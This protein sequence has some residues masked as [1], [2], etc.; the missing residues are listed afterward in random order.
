MSNP[1]FTSQINGD[2]VYLSISG[3]KNTTSKVYV[4][5]TTVPSAGNSSSGDGLTN[6]IEYIPTVSGISNN[7]ANFQVPINNLKDGTQYTININGKTSANG[8]IANNFA[9]GTFDYI[10]PPVCSDIDF[11]V[12]SGDQSVIVKMDSIADNVDTVKFYITEMNSTYRPC[13]IEIDASQ[14]DIYGQTVVID[15]SYATITNPGPA[16]RAY[17]PSDSTTVGAAI[18]DDSGSTNYTPGGGFMW[19]SASTAFQINLLRNVD[20]MAYSTESPPSGSV[21]YWNGART[22]TA[23]GTNMPDGNWID[24]Q[25]YALLINTDGSMNV[26]TNGGATVVEP[27]TQWTITG[28]GQTVLRGTLDL[29]VAD[30]TTLVVKGREYRNFSS[31]IE[32]NPQESFT[33]QMYTEVESYTFDGAPEDLAEGKVLTVAINT[34]PTG[35]TGTQIGICGY[36]EFTSFIFENGTGDNIDGVQPAELEVAIIPGNATGYS[37]DYNTVTVIPNADANTPADFIAIAG[38]DISGLIQPYDEKFVVLFNKGIQVA[39]LPDTSY[40]IHVFEVDGSNNYYKQFGLS[41]FSGNSVTH[42]SVAYAYNMVI[43]DSS[44]WTTDYTGLNGSNTLT[45]INGESYNISMAARNANENTDTH[46]D[47]T[48]DDNGYSDFTTPLITIIPSGYPD[49]PVFTLETGGDSLNQAIKLTIDGDISSTELDNGSDIFAYLVDVCGNSVQTFNYPYANPGDVSNNVIIITTSDGSTPLVNGV[50]YTIRVRVQNNNGI[51][52][53]SNADAMPSSIPS[54]LTFNVA[55]TLPDID[56]I[57]AL[58]SGKIKLTWNDISNNIDANTDVTGNGGLPTSNNGN[59]ADITYQYQVSER[60]N[61]SGTLLVDLSDNDLLTYTTDAS[62]STLA[63]NGTSYFARVRAINANG[64]GEWSY[65][66]DNATVAQTTHASAT[67]LVASF[68]PD[69]TGS[70]INTS[71]LDSFMRN[72]CIVDSGIVSLNFADIIGKNGLTNIA[73]TGGYD[74]TDVMFTIDNGNTNTYVTSLVLP[75]TGSKVVE[76]SAP[77]TGNN[78]CKMYLLNNVYNVASFENYVQTSVDASMQITNVLAT[79]S[80]SSST[81]QGDGTV[82]FQFTEATVYDA[83]TT[84][85]SFVAQLQEKYPQQTTS[86]GDI[87]YTT[88]WSNVIGAVKTLTSTNTTGAYETTFTGLVNGNLYRIAV[89]THS[90]QPLKD[91]QEHLIHVSD[92][93][94]VNTSYASGTDGAMPYGKPTISVTTIDSN[95]VTVLAQANGRIL[96]EGYMLYG[97]GTGDNATDYTINLLNFSD[98]DNGVNGGTFTQTIN[99]S[100]YAA[101]NYYTQIW[102]NDASYNFYYIADNLQTGTIDSAPSYL[103]IVSGQNGHFTVAKTDNVFGGIY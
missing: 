50:D 55:N 80:S 98:S 83:T 66:E 34:T 100:S 60:P 44:G 6:Y 40:V 29:S 31:D 57:S 18:A 19:N 103:T 92:S 69:M 53:A 25:Y 22:S 13:V 101:F 38:T 63:T 9:T 82:T 37:A 46:V 49:T 3:L 48:T 54:T 24:P 62:D 73:Y 67:A 32:A 8:S 10:A 20:V 74:I 58:G 56:E 97:V 16:Y 91:T 84:S 5:I 51:S 43:G 17:K 102:N 61:F 87:T 7:T 21:E 89:T 42:D 95:T 93:A 12:G 41:D 47:G 59:T 70:E 65:Y 52:D 11:T 79:T 26:Y 99:D 68:P 33:G 27:D 85:T 64:N 96:Q 39:E 72:Q 86:D 30:K 71:L 76:F 28:W 88:D 4:T 15:G 94:P 81:S 45:L 14:N 23:N 77:A 1:T 35:P 78:T 90:E 75:I 36:N 2:G